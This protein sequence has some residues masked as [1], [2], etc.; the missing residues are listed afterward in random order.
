MPLP[1]CERA[2]I[3]E[4]KLRDYLLSPTHRE[5][6]PKA[7]FFS[8]LGFDR[9]NLSELHDQLLLIACSG[10]I[11]KREQFRFG[12][13]FVVNGQLSSPIRGGISL[14]T[15]WVVDIG[16]TLPRFVTAYPL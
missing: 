2:I 6:A 13:K 5:G 11:V 16:S 9:T 3:A 8:A 10:E 12:E 7:K 15:I 4:A 14:T 1:N